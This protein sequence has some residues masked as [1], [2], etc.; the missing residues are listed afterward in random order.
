[1]FALVNFKCMIFN[2]L[3]KKVQDQPC[4]PTTL[5]CFLE[6][7]QP[8]WNEHQWTGEE[9]GNNSKW[10]SKSVLAATWI[11]TISLAAKKPSHPAPN[12]HFTGGCLR[13]TRV[14]GT[15]WEAS[16]LSVCQMHCVNNL[17]YRHETIL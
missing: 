9:G 10:C 4:A 14:Q 7:Y 8:S 3:C 15:L 5:Q 16:I 12:A 11:P 6:S 17:R 13:K 1:M 2:Y